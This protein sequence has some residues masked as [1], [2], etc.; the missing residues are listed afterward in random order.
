MGAAIDQR[1]DRSDWLGTIRGG[2]GNPLKTLHSDRPVPEVIATAF[3]DGL[4]ARG[5]L[6][7]AGKQQ[8]DLKVTILEFEC[9]Q[10]VRRD[11]H[12]NFR[13]TLLQNGSGR[14]IYSNEVK[15]DKLSGSLIVLDIGVFASLDDLRDLLLKTLDQAVD[16]ALDNPDFRAAVAQ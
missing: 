11:A 13:V 10:Y 14:Q 8:F 7:P 15:I 1:E 12:A 16:E 5:L 6:A 9:N 4:A 3:S 2:Y